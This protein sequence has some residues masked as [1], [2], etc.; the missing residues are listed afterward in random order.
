MRTPSMIKKSG[1]ILVKNL[2]EIEAKCFLSDLPKEIFVSDLKLPENVK[3]LRKPEETAT[4]LTL[5][6]T[7]EEP[8]KT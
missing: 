5:P 1:A 7:K 8:K 2:K 4:F 6:E 3:V